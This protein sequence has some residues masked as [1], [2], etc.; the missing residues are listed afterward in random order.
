MAQAAPV[1]IVVTLVRDALTDDQY[2]RTSIVLGDQAGWGQR[3]RALNV[4]EAVLLPDTGTVVTFSDTSG[5]GTVT[6]RRRTPLEERR[7][8][9]LLL[10]PELFVC[11][12]LVPLKLV[13]NVCDGHASCWYAQT[14]P[15]N[16]G[17][18]PDSNST[19]NCRVQQEATIKNTSFVDG[20]QDANSQQ[21][22]Y[23]TVGR[24][25][26]LKYFHQL[27]ANQNLSTS[28]SKFQRHL[29]PCRQVLTEGALAGKG[30]E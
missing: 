17:V 24:T 4:R 8:D 26:I 19:A 22:K 12:F 1:G 10:A 28:C 2:G 6:V 20:K 3:R 29:I 18:P 11:P 25:C 15:R 14:P 21:R 27:K 23:C 30:R 16:Y 7:I 9:P 13:A 5:T